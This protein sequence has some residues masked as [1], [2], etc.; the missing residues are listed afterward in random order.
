MNLFRSEDHVKNW[1]GYK[2]G[3]EEGIVD[4]YVLMKLF[5]VDTFTRRLDPDY[6]SRMK[7]YRAARGA[8]WGEIMKRS[9]FWQP[10]AP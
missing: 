5:S 7:E 8:A 10:K 2:S 6:V 1:S 9:P 3:T 4:L